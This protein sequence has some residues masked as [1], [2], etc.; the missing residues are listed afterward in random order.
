MDY[1]NPEVIISFKYTEKDLYYITKD[2]GR[3]RK[4][5]HI[6]I[7]ILSTLIFVF[8][9]YSIDTS[10]NLFSS[11]FSILFAVFLFSIS[12]IIGY[13]RILKLQAHHSYIGDKEFQALQYIEIYNDK[14]ITVLHDA[15]IA[16]F[17]DMKKYYESKHNILI[18]QNST[19]KT[20]YEKG[21]IIMPPIKMVMIPKKYCDKESLMKIKN[22]LSTSGIPEH[23]L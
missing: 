20:Y 23:L 12:S 16:Y 5:P 22:L 14:V 4:L 10:D 21:K 11:L 1:E 8:S 7:A 6:I 17:T 18:V 3:I 13:R 19:E 15:A 2:I 9:L